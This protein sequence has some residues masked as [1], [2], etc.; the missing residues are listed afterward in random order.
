MKSLILMR[1]APGAG[2][3][4]WIK[5]FGLQPYTLCADEI[6][7]MFQ[8]PVMNH[9]TGKMCIS[10]KNDNKV[11]KL[12]FELLEQRMQRGELCVVDACHSKTQDFSRYKKLAEEYRYRV[13]CIDLTSIPL[14]VCKLHNQGREEVKFVP[15]HI[16]ENIYS[17]FETQNPPSFVT[18]IKYDDIEKIKAFL[19]WK[20][21]DF[22][23]YDNVVV[24]GDIHGCFQP[25][26]SYFEI[27]PFNDK[28]KYVFTGDYIDRGIQNKEVVEWLLDNY[29]KPNVVLLEGNHEKW[30]KAFANGDYDVELKAGVKDKCRSSEFFFNT[31]EQL[32]DFDKKRLRELCRKFWQICY[33][34]FDGKKFI[35]SHAGVGFMPESIM[36]VSADSFIRGER[37][38]DPIDEWFCKNNH[39]ENLFQ[40][41]AHRNVED[42]ESN[43]FNHSFNLCDKV[44]FGKFL[45]VMEISK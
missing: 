43:K 20:P 3:S 1:G 5:T 30:L 21:M 17:R 27:H 33:F 23:E 16:L 8:G 15:E 36:K 10:Q 29:M 40:I 26:K 38:E 14:N 12:L 42:I 35:V 22:N 39:D 28:T 6:R 11:W 7:L 31:A 18:V 32:K 2:K 41:H 37:Y 44:E 9:E 24:F 13:Y 25:L 45:R 4:T 34:E 19:R